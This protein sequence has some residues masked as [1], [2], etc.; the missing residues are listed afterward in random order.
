M[1]G[2]ELQNDQEFAR[3]GEPAYSSLR[4]AGG[5]EAHWGR[6]PSIILLLVC[7]NVPVV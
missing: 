2:F 3:L 1:I 4:G 7:N 5:F 6:K